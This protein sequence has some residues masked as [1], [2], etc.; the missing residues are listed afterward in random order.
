LNTFVISMMRSSPNSFRTTPGTIII[1]CRLFIPHLHSSKQE[2]FYRTRLL[3]IAKDAQVPVEG[4][5]GV[6]AS[7]RRDEELIH[8]IPWETYKE[9][10]S[11][12]TEG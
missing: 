5:S 1:S 10:K 8:Q 9:E 7:Y 12:K 3:H 11:W 2:D 6:R 4:M